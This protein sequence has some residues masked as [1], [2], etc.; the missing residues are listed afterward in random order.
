LSKVYTVA[1][2]MSD[3]DPAALAAY[4]A[5]AGPAIIAGG[6][7]MIARGM[8]LATFE[9]GLEKRAIIIEWDSLEQATAIYATPAYRA[10][11]AKLGPSV[12]RDI[13]ILAATE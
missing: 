9:K 13:R 2:Y 7:R 11:V 5:L 1:S 8:P 4:A 12:E 3:G 10:A 6:G